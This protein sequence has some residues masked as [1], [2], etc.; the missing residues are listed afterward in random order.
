MSPHDKKQP[1]YEPPDAA[2]DQVVQ[3]LTAILTRVKDEPLTPRPLSP[4]AQQAVAQ[5][6][7]L[8]LTLDNETARPRPRPPQAK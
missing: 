4:E 2:Q 3:L 7:Q 5:Y 8:L 6:Q 1:P